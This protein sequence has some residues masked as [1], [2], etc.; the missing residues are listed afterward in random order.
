M[1]AVQRQKVWC[2]C[3]VSKDLLQVVND[4]ELITASKVRRMKTSQAQQEQHNQSWKETGESVPVK[5]A[6]PEHDM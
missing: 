6:A 2:D 3:T 5:S 1:Y 4:K